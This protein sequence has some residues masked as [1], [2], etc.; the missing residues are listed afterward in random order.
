MNFFFKKNKNEGS[1][2]SWPD[3]K[4]GGEAVGICFVSSPGLASLRCKGPKA[5]SIKNGKRNQG[6]ESRLVRRLRGLT[7]S[8]HSRSKGTKEGRGEFPS[9]NGCTAPRSGALQN[10]AGL[11]KLPPRPLPRQTQARTSGKRGRLLFSEGRGAQLCSCSCVKTSAWVGVKDGCAGAGGGGGG[12]SLSKGRHD[13]TPQLGEGPAAAHF[14]LPPPPTQP[15]ADPA[16]TS[17]LALYASGGNQDGLNER[18]LGI[19]AGGGEE[20]G[21]S[22]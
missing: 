5:S 12:T 17:A 13:L 3:N 1:L 10:M 2:C 15:H 21:K 16:A 19:W 11:L 22:A 8:D 20:K 18:W 9:R 4:V 6:R 7:K 14:H